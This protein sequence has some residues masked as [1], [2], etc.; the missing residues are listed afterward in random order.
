MLFGHQND[1][2]NKP[3]TV[4]P[5]TSDTADSGVNPLAVDPSTGASLPAMAP[6]PAPVA[7]ADLVQPSVLNQPA[8]PTTDEPST[9]LPPVESDATMPF[10]TETPAATTEASDDS[11]S[12]SSDDPMPFD[13]P[14][15]DSSTDA[16]ATAPE[17]AA[18]PE[19][20]TP[21]EEPAPADTSAPDPSSDALL[22]LKQQAL[23][24]L[25]PLVDQLDQTPEERFRTT[26]MMIQSTDNQS[27]I[28]SAYEAAEKITD[29]K[30]RAQAL[31][32]IINEINYFTQQKPAS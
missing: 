25:S 30:I 19:V 8:T 18:A 20:D 27:L 10:D 14:T 31:L 22:A 9:T 21:A 3:T 5:T 2:N 6:P 26:M 23:A 28:Q 7:P 24:E 13:T 16:P 29:E 12:T 15:A 1:D 32:D 4:E 11:T 17:A